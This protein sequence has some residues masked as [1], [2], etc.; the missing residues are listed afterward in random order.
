MTNDYTTSEGRYSAGFTA[1]YWQEEMHQDHSIY[2]PHAWI[3]NE[4]WFFEMWES[5]DEIF[6]AGYNDGMDTRESLADPTNPFIDGGYF[7]ANLS[8][9]PWGSKIENEIDHRGL[10]LTGRG[11]KDLNFYHDKDKFDGIYWIE[12]KIDDAV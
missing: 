1:G 3:G 2:H 11:T 7:S 8:G 10:T 9:F 4:E 5:E 6:W 12:E